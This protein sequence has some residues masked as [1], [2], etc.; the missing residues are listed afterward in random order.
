MADVASIDARQGGQIVLSAIV[1][2][3]FFG[4]TFARRMYFWLMC[5]GLALTSPAVA[6]AHEFE[7]GHVE[8][9]VAVV[10]RGNTGQIEYSIGLNP[11]TRQQ[12]IRFWSDSALKNAPTE[13]ASRSSSSPP[14][15][16][17]DDENEPLP[18]TALVSAA[19]TDTP[20]DFFLKL[21]AANVIS[22]LK[23]T[24]NGDPLP[25]ELISSSA[26]ARHHVDV[27]VTLKF[28]IP[29]QSPSPTA[30]APTTS[31]TTSPADQNALIDLAIVDRNFRIETQSDGHHPLQINQREINQREI[32]Q[33]EIALKLDLKTGQE[34]TSDLPNWPTADRHRDRGEIK[35]Q[36]N[37]VTRGSPSGSASMPVLSPI[38]M[39]G[40]FRYACKATGS[41]VLT[42]SN[43][44]SILI[45]AQRQID[46]ELSCDRLL[47]AFKIE[48][49]LIIIK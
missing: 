28:E 45:R 19:A 47:E 27:T 31:P 33:R 15:H 24:A 22:R 9:S 41:T 12:L 36:E 3:T 26:S 8:R 42:R 1:S 49:Q 46:A 38:A 7:D 48:A 17:L 32:D 25:L 37:G 5:V 10:I 13:S 23:V 30:P 44:A 29:L 16:A 11:Q 18:D 14:Q 2:M 34:I 40:G 43:V 4:V 35:T 20:E 6:V 39:G 21:A